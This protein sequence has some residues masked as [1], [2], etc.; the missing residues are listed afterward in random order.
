MDKT[1]MVLHGILGLTIS[2]TSFADCYQV[3]H[4]DDWMLRT[5]KTLKLTDKQEKDIS[6]I[7]EDTEKELKKYHQEFLDIQGKINDDFR[8]NSFSEEQ[9]HQWVED[10]LK[11]YKHVLDLRLKERIDIY[12]QL[13]PEQQKS[14]LNETN[15][16]IKNHK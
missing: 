15:N 9:K 7:S 14:F 16:W 11:M 6:K 2:M 10:E 12:Q 4:K 8:N 13:T 3:F 5:A 1:K